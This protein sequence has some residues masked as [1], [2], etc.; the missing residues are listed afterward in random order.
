[1][2]LTI[3]IMKCDSTSLCL[4][5]HILNTFCYCTYHT[6]LNFLSGLCRFGLIWFHWLSANFDTNFAKSWDVTFSLFKSSALCLGEKVWTSS[7][8]SSLP[9]L[10]LLH[11]SW[12]K[13]HP[14]L[15][16]VTTVVPL[17][18]PHIPLFLSIPSLSN[19][20]YLRTE[21]FSH[22]YFSSTNL[23]KVLTGYYSLLFEQFNDEPQLQT[24]L[25]FDSSQFLSLRITPTLLLS[26]FYGRIF[27]SFYEL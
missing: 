25:S 16:K 12:Q 13:Y 9:K 21:F 10:L 4:I 27:S 24:P 15:F 14:C 1:M 22:S 11:S 7:P 17:T 8:Q 23:S 19:G 26:P 5:S 20:N 6:H 18:I 2:C 3:S